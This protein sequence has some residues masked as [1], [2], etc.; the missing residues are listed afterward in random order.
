VVNLN[1]RTLVKLSGFSIMGTLQAVLEF[2]EH[3]FGKNADDSIV[4]P[5]TASVLHINWPL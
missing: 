2:Q 4:G 3:H 1:R 5:I